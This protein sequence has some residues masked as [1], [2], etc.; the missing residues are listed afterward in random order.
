MKK[1]VV[2]IN[3]TSG[4]GLNQ[5]LSAKIKKVLLKYDYEPEVYLTEYRG[6]AEE[7]VEKAE[8][9][10][11]ISVGGDGTFYEVIYQLEQRM[12]LDICMVLVIILL[13]T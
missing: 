7:I 5:K 11:L 2:V 13:R 12:I 6:H 1:C 3:P 9:D 4:R 8:C 10:L